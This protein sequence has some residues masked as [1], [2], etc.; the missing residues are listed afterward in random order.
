MISKEFSR[1]A[2]RVDVLHRLW[3]A[4]EPK[5]KK[6][7]IKNLE[8]FV[9]AKG[10]SVRLTSFEVRLADF[11]NLFVVHKTHNFSSGVWFHFSYHL[12]IEKRQIEHLPTL[13]S[14]HKRSRGEEDGR[15]ELCVRLA[16]SAGRNAN[17]DRDGEEREERR[18]AKIGVAEN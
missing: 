12:M 3:T 1:E 5:I 18:K 11:F 15:K 6:Y 17:I 9:K 7:S 16:S 13:Y 14:K 8:H 10:S 4:L 2:M